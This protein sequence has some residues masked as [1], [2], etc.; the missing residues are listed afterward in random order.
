RR[1]SRDN[2]EAMVY[3]KRETCGLCRHGKEEPLSARAISRKFFCRNEC[4]SSKRELCKAILKGSHQGARGVE[5]W[6]LFP[7]RL[8]YRRCMSK[9]LYES[10]RSVSRPNRFFAEF[11]RT[12]SAVSEIQ[13]MAFSRVRVSHILPFALIA[14]IAMVPAGCSPE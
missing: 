4:Y 10:F 1:N 9:M 11:P 13:H 14:G 5:K 6:S 12:V 3:L 8:T 2:K 7:F